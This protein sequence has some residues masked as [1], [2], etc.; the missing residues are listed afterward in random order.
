MSSPRGRG[1]PR[2]IKPE[3]ELHLR[4]AKIRR[5]RRSSKSGGEEG[6]AVTKETNGTH[7][8]TQA[9][10]QNWLGQSQGAVTN[11]TSPT[12]GEPVEGRQAED[13]VK[14][15]AQ[16]Q[17]Q[18]FNLLP[19]EPCDPNSLTE[20]QTPTSTSTPPKGPH[21]LP[22]HLPA[23]AAPLLQVRSIPPQ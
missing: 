23:L 17:G 18:W 21:Q 6:P 16:K 8:L 2:K 5:R 11:G 12:T 9:A 15:M 4:T 20:P 10:F 3:V 19:K 14:E 1:R 7:D 13:S 22:S